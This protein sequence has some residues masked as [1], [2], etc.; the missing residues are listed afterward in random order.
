M[1]SSV[2]KNY[3]YNICYQGLVLILPLITTPYIS[4]ALGADGV[5]A[6]GYTESI[7]QYFVLFGCIGLNLYGQR[8]VAY[9]QNDK[10]KRTLIFFEL[11]LVR[12]ITVSCSLLF[13]EFTS[14]QSAKYGELFRIQIIE[15]LASMIDI[16]WYFQG[17]EEFKKIVIRN[18][19]VKI[20][21]VILIFI[22]IHSEDDLVLY[23]L[24]YTSTLLLGNLSMWMY[25]PKYIR[26]VKIADL[27]C[28]RHI[29][30]ALLLFIPQIATNMYNLLDK[31][32]IGFLTK[33]D[34]EVAYYEQA[35]KIMKMALSIPTALGTVM[36]PRIAR[37]FGEGKKDEIIQYL[38]K[39]VRFVCMLTFPLCAGI[40][41]ISK[42]LVPWFFGSGYDKVTINLCIISPIIIIVGISNVIGVQY[43]LP[44][45]KQKQY[46]I[47]VVIGTL[48]NFTLNSVCIPIFL[49]VGAAVASIIAELS[50]TVY[51]LIVVR[52]D[53]EFNHTIKSIYKY[54]IAAMVMLC[55][56]LWPYFCNIDGILCTILQGITGVIV[57]GGLLILL[58]DEMV[59]FVIRNY[60]RKR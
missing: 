36:L 46:T 6:F 54:I 28:K 30:P 50:V 29:K 58:K 12:F 13:F 16:S 43:L 22:F 11:L 35:Q 17:L 49:S 2:I 27:N 14:C 39:S 57:Y 3:I 44:V 32:M 52:Q 37:M 40:I 23:T 55:V 8:E 53:F 7:S 1:K 26:K 24:I 41:A 38:Q 48:V 19:L 47:S 5:G 18:T 42:E 60:I 31:S 45:G 4:R 20:L 9:C 33:N 51:Q 34:A 15:I 10:E 59:Y 25:V 56:C 21:G